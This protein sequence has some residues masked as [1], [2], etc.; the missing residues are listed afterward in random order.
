[1]YFFIITLDITIFQFQSGNTPLHYAVKD[2]RVEIV[3]LL[4]ERTDIQN[5]KVNKVY[6]E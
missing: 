6:N 2:G 1:M 3:K 4:L 5:Y